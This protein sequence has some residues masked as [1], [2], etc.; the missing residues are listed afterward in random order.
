MSITNKEIKKDP[1]EVSEEKQI[2]NAIID[3]LHNNEE[4]TDAAISKAIGIS[5][6][7]LEKHSESIK[8]MLSKL[9]KVRT[10]SVI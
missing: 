3:L 10:P 7:R 5:T 4:V 8:A 9:K 1:I 6:M 2:R